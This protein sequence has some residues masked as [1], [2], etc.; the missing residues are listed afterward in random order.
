MFPSPSSAF[1]PARLDQRESS[2]PHR[3]ATR[4]LS[5]ED[6]QQARKSLSSREDYAA[7]G[8]KPGLY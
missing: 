7:Q 8:K 6:E 1:R 3:L 4:K 2:K 5:R